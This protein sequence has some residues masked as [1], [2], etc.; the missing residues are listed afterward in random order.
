[1][2]LLEAFERDLA[3]VDSLDG[4]DEITDALNHDVGKYITRIAKNVSRD[5]T[6]LAPTLLAMLI[7]DLYETHRGQAA[8]VRFATL[9]ASLPAPMRTSPIIE[10]VAAR[11]A[12]VDALQAR[13]R[14]GE[15]NAAHEAMRESLCIE[16]H[17]S[18]IARATRRVCNV[19]GDDA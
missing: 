12:V 2:S 3:S 5:A 17:L 14:A 9:R 13:V 15:M 16:R 19:R 18:D 4:V 1:M 7:K 10:D 8:S 11:L 6:T